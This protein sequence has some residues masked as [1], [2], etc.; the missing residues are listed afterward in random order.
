MEQQTLFYRYEAIQY[1]STDECGEYC[2]PR[3]TNP[4]IEL[5]TYVLKKETE[6]GYWIGYDIS[7]SYIKWIPKKSKSRYAYP[8]KE[9]ALT[10][11]IKRT[12]KRVKILKNQMEFCQIALQKACQINPEDKKPFAQKAKS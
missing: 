7:S 5:K 9:E 11:Y 12:E 6:K 4:T 2:T 1:A 3:F 10:N 8:T